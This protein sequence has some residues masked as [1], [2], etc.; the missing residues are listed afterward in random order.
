MFDSVFYSVAYFGYFMTFYIGVVIETYFLL[1]GKVGGG[2][3]IIF[4]FFGVGL[5][6]N[7]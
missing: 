4:Y 1:F 3:I 6:V 2:G 7:I 5:G